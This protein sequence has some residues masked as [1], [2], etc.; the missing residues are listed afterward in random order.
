MKKILLGFLIVI[1]FVLIYS[2]ANDTVERIMID[3]MINSFIKNSSIERETEKIVF[4]R[5]NQHNYNPEYTFDP[6]TD[7]PYGF[8]NCG[9][10][11][12]NRIGPLD[13]AFPQWMNK[14][15]AYVFGTHACLAGYGTSVYEITG[16]GEAPSIDYILYP[17]RG[18]TLFDNTSGI[19]KGVNYWFA[20]RPN[21]EY[22]GL[23][24]KNAT[25]ADKDNVVTFMEECLA[26]TL[27]DEG[28][29]NYAFILNSDT[30]Y[31]CGDLISR[32]WASFVPQNNNGKRFNLNR[33]GFFTTTM[34]ISLSSD[35][36][37]FL[38]CININGVSHYYYL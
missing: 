26:K 5:V 30:K 31:Y 20:N 12:I 22:I 15:F 18:T 25:P 13:D 36:Y 38:Y 4:H 11:Y 9:D 1:S 34:D 7:Y 32:A 35:V 23:R 10:I 16:W 28:L 2:F 19:R 3:N 6:F 21:T 29:Y 24:V 14:T 8:I 17:N 33:D 37:M 27:S